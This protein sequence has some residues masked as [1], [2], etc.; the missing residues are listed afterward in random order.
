M[1]NSTVIQFAISVV[2]TIIPWVFPDLAWYYK[3]IIGLFV[4]LI[5]F[6]I[7]CARLGSK[8]KSLKK[9]LQDTTQRHQALAAQFEQ[10]GAQLRQYQDVI[11]N[12]SFMLHLAI[13][14]TDQAKLE[15]IYRAFLTN[16]ERLQN[17]GNED[18][19]ENREDH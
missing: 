12:F 2:L 6:C 11:S 14:N 19:R 3:I 4:I 13:S 16:Q 17:G 5:S 7:Y 1:D 9:D 18:D 15:D 10:K 8:I